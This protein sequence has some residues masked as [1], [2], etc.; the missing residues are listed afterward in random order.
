MGWTTIIGLAV[1]LAVL[2]AVG[3]G[4]R[5]IY[6]S[7]GLSHEVEDLKNDV[8]KKRKVYKRTGK[9]LDRL[10]DALDRMRRP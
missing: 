9:H 2:G 4:I 7:G 10:R 3:Y 1:G 8:K 5:S 6:K